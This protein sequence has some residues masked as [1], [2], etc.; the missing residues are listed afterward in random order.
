MVLPSCV[1]VKRK[2]RAACWEETDEKKK[3]EGIQEEKKWIL[4]LVCEQKDGERVG[5]ACT[6]RFT[7]VNLTEYLEMS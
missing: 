2:C 5:Q 6:S 4:A 3:K 1:H 7:S